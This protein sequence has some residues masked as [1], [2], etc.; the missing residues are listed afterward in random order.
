MH[1]KVEAELVLSKAKEWSKR[2]TTLLEQP[3][4]LELEIEKE[5]IFETQERL[6]IAELKIYISW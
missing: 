1:I 3:K 6:K 4:L 2:K 5:K